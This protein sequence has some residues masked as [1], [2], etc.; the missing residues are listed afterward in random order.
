M[1]ERPATRELARFEFDEHGLQAWARRLGARLRGGDVLLLVGP[2]GAGKTTFA[3]ALA[4]GLGVDRPDRVSSPTY[5][6]CMVHRG[7]IGMVHVDLFR[8]IEAESA[9]REGDE[10]GAPGARAVLSS[11][12]EALGLEQGE[13]PPPGQI[14]LVEW[15]DAWADPPAEHLLITL[16]G[17]PDSEH[18]RRIG[19][20]GAGSRWSTDDLLDLWKV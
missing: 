18:S 13:L 16:E 2:M 20:L 9:A 1:N 4:E 6:V 11:A 14:L 15:A 5:T 10:S 3:R 19:V 7:P 8:L 17:V 12:F